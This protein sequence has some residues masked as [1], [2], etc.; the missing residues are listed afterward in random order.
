M[1][2]DASS[3]RQLPNVTQVSISIGRLVLSK[4]HTNWNDFLVL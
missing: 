2:E 4:S 3:T 1:K